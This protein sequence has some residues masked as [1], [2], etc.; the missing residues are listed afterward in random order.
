MT[1]LWLTN[2]VE[3]HDIQGPSGTLGQALGVNFPCHTNLPDPGL[4]LV[5]LFVLSERSEVH[6]KAELERVS[7]Y[8]KPLVL[9]P[10]N[11]QCPEQLRDHKGQKTDRK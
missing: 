10:L 7:L 3:I 8:Q 9:G 11:Y 4:G 1:I 6:G 5:T 2:P